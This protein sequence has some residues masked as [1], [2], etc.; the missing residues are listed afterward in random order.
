[1]NTG[2]KKLQTF[3]ASPN[4]SGPLTLLVLLYVSNMSPRLPPSVL[5][6]FENKYFK[7]VTLTLILLSLRVHPVLAVTFLAGFVMLVNGANNKPL[8]EF[9]ENTPNESDA[10]VITSP[11]AE[12]SADAAAVNL[13]TS[14]Q[15]PQQ[16]NGMLQNDVTSTIQPTIVETENGPI[17]VNPS[18]VIAP[19]AVTKPNGD[20]VLVKPDITFVDAEPTEAPMTEAPMTEAPMTEAPMTEEPMELRI[21]PNMDLEIKTPNDNCQSLDYYF[22]KSTD[23]SKVKPTNWGGLKEY[24]KFSS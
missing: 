5:V 21:T 7:F 11:N 4:V 1:M 9:L 19:L 23:M 12:I 15:E 18:V 3:L 22:K 24:K 14:L 2:L 17:V 20:V 10:G 6:L 8:L 16:V 13:D